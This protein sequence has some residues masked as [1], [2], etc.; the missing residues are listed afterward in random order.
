[1]NL[2]KISLANIKFKP[3]NALLSLL[4]LSFGVGL[5]SLLIQIESQFN[6]QYHKNIDKIDLVLG[7]KGSALQLIL[8]SVYQVDAPTGNIPLKTAKK[9]MKNMLVETSIPLAYGDNYKDY[10]IVGTTKDYSELFETELKEGVLFEKSFDACLGANVAKKTGLKIGDNFYSS[11]GL[12]Y[13]E[14]SENDANE[15]VH[16]DH[17][18]TVTGIF[19]ESGTVIDKVIITSV[20]SL[21]DVHEGHDHEGHDDEEHDHSGH[22]H[23]EEEEH[24]E[25]E[26]HDHEG[27]ENHAAHDEQKEEK[28]NLI[29]AAS[30]QSGT[31]L[32]KKEFENNE[33]TASLLMFKKRSG[34]TSPA[35]GI[36]PN[37]AEKVDLLTALPAV[38]MK[39]LESQLGIGMKSMFW[40]GILITVISFLSVF[41][42]LYNSLKERKYEIA[43]MRTMG[44]SVGK[45]YSMILLEGLI[46]SVLGFILAMIF[47]RIGLWLVS[48][49]IEEQFKFSFS[50]MS[51]LPYEWILLGITLIV[52]ALASFLPAISAVEKDISKTLS[53]G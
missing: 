36:L 37:M 3:L 13:T 39:R 9:I 38:E 27:H 20:K 53:N 8:S 17:A 21:W 14:S 5:I 23:A 49:R 11:H 18:F 47:S 19:E 25:H 29:S 28:E 4:L 6:E 2:L 1:M 43:L 51:I 15:H 44:S 10:R 41:V 33:I 12:D 32:M 42:S 50:D 46:L 30:L 26:G 16:D 22:D 24:H 35:I 7:A 45:I 31:Y 48:S 40:L 52:G 34:Q